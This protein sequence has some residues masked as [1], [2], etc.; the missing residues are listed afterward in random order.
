MVVGHGGK[1]ED[2]GSS[3]GEKRKMVVDH[4]GKEEENEDKT[5]CDGHVT[6]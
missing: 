6:R 3:W 4:E 2:G 5:A 1:E